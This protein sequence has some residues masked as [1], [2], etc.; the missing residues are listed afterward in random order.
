[1]VVSVADPGAVAGGLERLGLLHCRAF[2]VHDGLP[3]TKFCQSTDS[4]QA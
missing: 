1:M 4:A 2:P 3:G